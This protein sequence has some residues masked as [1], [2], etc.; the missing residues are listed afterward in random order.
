MKHNLPKECLKESLDTKKDS[1]HNS[2]HMV[3][4]TV[5]SKK[6]HDYNSILEDCKSE[7]VIEEELTQK[8]KILND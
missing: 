8:S 2:T 7:C 6:C 5:L 4:T 3:I 1:Q